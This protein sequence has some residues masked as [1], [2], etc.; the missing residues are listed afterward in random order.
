MALSRARKLAA[1]GGKESGPE[2]FWAGSCAL[3]FSIHFR[4]H[5]LAAQRAVLTREH[6]VKARMRFSR[7]STRDGRGLDKASARVQHDV[8]VLEE[9]FEGIPCVISLLKTPQ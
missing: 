6:T 9:S 1:G 3:Q 5:T 2:A 8:Q 4:D 7:S